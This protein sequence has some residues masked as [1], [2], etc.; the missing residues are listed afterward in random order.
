MFS[1]KLE[2]LIKATLQDGLLT[3]QEKAAIIKRA[4]AEGEDI[5]EVDIYIQSLLQERQQTLAKEAQAA[6]TERIIAQK[7]EREAKQKADREEQKQEDARKRKCPICGTYVTGLTNVCPECKHVL[8]ENNSAEGKNKNALELMNRIS[9]AAKHLDFDGATF[10]TRTIKNKVKDSEVERLGG[11]SKW[12]Q[13]NGKELKFYD[14][15]YSND[16]YYYWE[17][18]FDYYFSD[19]SELETLYGELPNVQKFIHDQ[20]CNEINLIAK[21]ISMC[22]RFKE[23][24][25]AETLISMLS[26]MY[27]SMPEAQALYAKFQKTIDK[28]AAEDN[29]F[30][31]GYAV[32]GVLMILLLI[33]ILIVTQ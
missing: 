4:Q 32:F 33:I 6:E 27:P 31:I 2:N 10:L 20:R 14:D 30:Y 9:K 23:H 22:Q 24:D 19:L 25:E 29:R 11:I 13:V 18:K 17:E 16:S 3:E 12:Q 21:R 5:E 15:P 26:S 7:K 8:E 28:K 1:E